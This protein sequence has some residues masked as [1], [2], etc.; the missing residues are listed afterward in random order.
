MLRIAL[1]LGGLLT[2]VS[3]AAALDVEIGSSGSQFARLAAAKLQAVSA[4]LDADAAGRSAVDRAVEDGVRTFYEARGHRPLWFKGGDVSQQMIA[5][6]RRMDA[7]DSLGLDPA[8]YATPHFAERRY[9][10]PRRLG[11]ADVE[12]SRAVARFVTH[13]AS[14][15]IDPRAVSRLITLE[16]ERPDVGEVLARLSQTSSVGVALV[17]YEPQH[18]QYRALKAKLAELRAASHSD[19]RIVVPEGPMLKPGKT[20]ERVVVLRERLAVEP[21]LDA[22]PDLYDDALVDAVKAFQKEHGLA[23]DGIVGPRT[24]LALNGRSPAEDIASIIANMERWRWMPRELGLFHVLVN[25]PEFRVRVIDEGNVVHAT[26]VIVGK[27]SNPTPTFS[28]NIDHLVVNP[29]WNVPVSILSKEMMPAIRA[30]PHGYF[31]RHGYEVLANVGGRMRQVHPARI[32]WHAVNPRSVRVRQTPG[33]HNA[34]GRIKFMFPNQHSVYLHDTPSKSLFKRDRRAFS[35]GCVRVQNPLDFAD[36]ILPNAAPEWNA[37]RLERLYGGRERRVNLE[38]SVPVH[39][40]YFTTTVAED[41]AVSRF[42]DIYGYDRKMTEFM[43]S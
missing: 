42:E 19:D 17:R 14:G 9:Y 35:H 33:S 22:E 39:L 13:I 21:P 29:Y 20:D 28:H 3:P 26:R 25:V 11:R 40:S 37:S 34:L 1:L 6:R 23:V 8:D 30:N 18:A 16:P 2:A 43:G 31:A 36:A 7:A 4:A 12:F 15:R 5:L 32:N 24:L 38:Q 27:P 10:N 41:G